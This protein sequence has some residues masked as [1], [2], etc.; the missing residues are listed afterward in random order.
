MYILGN[1]I[2]S[3]IYSSHGF[4]F[5]D[6][7]LFYVIDNPLRRYEIFISD[8]VKKIV[9]FLGM[10]YDDIDKVDEEEFYKIVAHSPHFKPRRFKEDVSEGGSLLLSNMA[11]F[12][13][14][15]THIERY[16]NIQLADAFDFFKEEKFEDTFN[17]AT[18]AHKNYDVLKGKFNGRVILKHVP[19]FEKTK[20][21]DT[22]R[23][24]NVNHF[25][26]DI[27][28]DFFLLSSTEEDIVKE[29]LKSCN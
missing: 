23:H 2:I 11:E 19:E 15:N 26:S 21:T 29:F 3:R 17:K 7:G 22:L 28:R 1:A 10:K 24:F 25:K 16:T 8:D 9:E 4:K 12:L 5:N 14:T 6:K 13:K 20:L 27:E 18:T